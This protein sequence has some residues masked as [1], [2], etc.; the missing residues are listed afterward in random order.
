VASCRFCNRTTLEQFIDLGH[1][2]PSDAFLTKEQLSEPEVHYPLRL[3]VCTSCWLVQ[4]DSC[5]KPEQMFNEG[6]V[7]YSSESPANVS[8]AKEYVDMMVERFGFGKDSNVVEIGSN[9]GYLLQWFKERKIS[10]LGYDPSGAAEKAEQKGIVTR[11]TFFGVHAAEMLAK[12]GNFYEPTQSDLICG[13]NVLN[14]QP[15][16]N[17]FVEGLRIALKPDG[18]ITFE[19]P[20]L[21][22]MVDLC[23]FD[24]IYHEHYSY[25]SFLTICGIFASHGLEI[26]DVDEIPEH[27]GSLRIY[28]QH[29][30][31]RQK[32]TERVMNLL[33]KEYDKGM[34]HINYYAGFGAKVRDIKHNLVSFL[35]YDVL[36]TDIVAIYSTPAK[37]STLLNYSGIK[38]DLIPF[39]VDRSPHKQGKYLPGSHIPVYD[40]EYLKKVQPDYVLILAWNLKEEIMEQLSYI[41]QWNGKFVVAIPTLEVL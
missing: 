29:E 16:I 35:L 32:R 15:D 2:P 12:G 38:S 7:Y 1:M 40:E 22:N 11:R 30:L 27:G 34:A 39:A 37:G 24:T 26:F 10:C 5:I 8:H 36:P 21:M 28:A 20:H 17:D 18:I 4:L 14:H 33:K 23:Q 13:I 6:Y 31:K 3:D 9:D 19:F 41:R 25:F